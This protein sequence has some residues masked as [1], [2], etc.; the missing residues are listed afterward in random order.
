MTNDKA[1]SEHYTHGKLLGAI[2]ASIS[3]LGKTIDSITIEDQSQL[4]PGV[5]TVN[6]TDATGCVLTESITVWEPNPI[7]T[8]FNVTN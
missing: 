3:K 2:Q 8:N 6:I 5:Y 4:S 1:V 7:I